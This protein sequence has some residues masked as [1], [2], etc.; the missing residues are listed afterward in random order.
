[1]E[2]ISKNSTCRKFSDP[3]H[4]SLTLLRSCVLMV[5]LLIAFTVHGQNNLVI[6]LVGSPSVTVPLSD[7]QKITFDDNNMLLKTAS[8]TNSYLLN[9]IVSITFL[10]DEVGVEEVKRKKEVKVYV[11]GY[12]E[13]V[14]DSPH[15]INCLTVF[16]LTGR[17]VANSSQNKMNVNN[18]PVGLYILQVAT[19]QGFV[20]KK[21]IKNN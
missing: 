6:N 14:V 15:Q 11:N 12:G 4:K 3:N 2:K 8:G 1:M 19:E 20:S 13:I 7:I 16:D 21:F 9:K 10:E 18:L 5:F 17:E